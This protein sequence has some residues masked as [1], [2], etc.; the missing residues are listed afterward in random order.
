ME[1]YRFEWGVYR[2]D[3]ARV[4]NR[5]EAVNNWAA[6]AVVVAIVVVGIAGM[7][8]VV[9]ALLIPPST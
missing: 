7:D 5:S 1:V 4:D 8:L 2:K 9:A 3:S 6:V